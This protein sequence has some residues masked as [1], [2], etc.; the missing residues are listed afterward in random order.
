MV[1]GAMKDV[2]KNEVIRKLK[3]KELSVLVSSTVIE[4]GVTIP[5]LKSLVVVNADRYG[6]STLH[7]LRGRVA[8]HGGNGYFFVYLPDKVKPDTMA[9]LQLL[10]R[11]KDGFSLAE[12]DAE[13]R[14]YGDLTR[15]GELQHGASRCSIFLG[16]ELVPAEIHRYS[17]AVSTFP[18]S[19]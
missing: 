5:A 8:R 4:I 3:K 17:E 10:E 7:Q 2:E 9:R 11:F 16:I 19:A 14:G 1:Y 13:M 15:E 12:N 6:L 18:I